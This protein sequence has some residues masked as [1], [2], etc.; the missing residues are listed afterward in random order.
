MMIV[1]NFIYIF[2]SHPQNKSYFRRENGKKQM[3]SLAMQALV[4]F[5][6]G[7][8]RTGAVGALLRVVQCVWGYCQFRGAD[9]GKA[10]EQTDQ[11]HQDAHQWGPGTGEP[12][13][14]MFLPGWG[15]R[16]SKKLGE[17]PEIIRAG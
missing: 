5:H 10:A 14:R 8:C 12:R 6:F 4:L 11:L 16:G 3:W 15:S 13:E 17:V 2:S 1:R 9:I 7:I